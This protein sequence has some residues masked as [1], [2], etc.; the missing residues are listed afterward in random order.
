VDLDS[1]GEPARHDGNELDLGIKQGR[2][3][4]LRPVVSRDYDAF[5]ALATQTHSGFRWRYRGASPSP[6]LFAR[7]LWD[8]VLVQQAVISERHGLL[9][10]VGLYNNNSL[11]KHAYGFALSAP[12]VAGSGRVYEAL[13][14]LLDY[15]F[16]MWDFNKIYFEVPGFNVPQMSSAKVL[17]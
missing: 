17:C 4:I 16:R 9:G 6:E 14:L 2:R 12:D 3:V 11:A 10:L 8:G 15:G 7:Q 13:L 1:E 5:Y